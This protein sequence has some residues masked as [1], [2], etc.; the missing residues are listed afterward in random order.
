VEIVNRF[1]AADRLAFVTVVMKGRCPIPAPGALP[2]L[3]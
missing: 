2:A 3:L 1:Y